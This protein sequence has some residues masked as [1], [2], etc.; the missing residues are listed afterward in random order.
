ME[1]CENHAT[2]NQIITPIATHGIVCTKL[3]L[4]TGKILYCCC[5]REEEWD[6][7]T[8]I[9]KKNSHVSPKKTTGN[10]NRRSIEFVLFLLI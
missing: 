3:L 1:L 10:I 2:V 9:K 6:P 4:T 7:K 5:S 8:F